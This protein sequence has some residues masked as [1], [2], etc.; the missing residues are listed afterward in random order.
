MAL[1]FVANW[2]LLGSP[3][4]RVTLAAQLLFYG[5][6]AAGRAEWLHGTL[7]RA[8]SV[9]HYFVKMNAAVVVGFWRFLRSA[10]GPAW[11]RTARA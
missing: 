7:R 2:F 3:L 5:L 11:E 9:A 1:A 8:A 4:Y 10:Q 6:A